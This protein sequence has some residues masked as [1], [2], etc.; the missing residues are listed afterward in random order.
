M[1]QVGRFP[2]KTKGS[3]QSKKGGT[4]PYMVVT[5]VYIFGHV[6]RLVSYAKDVPPG[7]FSGAGTGVVQDHCA[8]LCLLSTL[9]TFRVHSKER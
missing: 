9:L 4:F 5:H 3:Q 7:S 1:V 6:F 2:D 8:T